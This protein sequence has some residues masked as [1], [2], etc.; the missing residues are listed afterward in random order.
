MPTGMPG[1]DQLSPSYL[2]PHELRGLLAAGIE[3]RFGGECAWNKETQR[4]V[5][6]YCAQKLVGLGHLGVL[7]KEMFVAD[8]QLANGGVLE[9][10][11]RTRHLSERAADQ[12]NHAKRQSPSC[13][14]I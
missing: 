5:N 2:S 9:I 11:V 3:E 14:S 7:G 4:A 8:V 10:T 12:D 6:A 1:F 13:L